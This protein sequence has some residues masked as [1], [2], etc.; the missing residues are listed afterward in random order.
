MGWKLKIWGGG[1]V[2]LF[3]SISATIPLPVNLSFLTGIISEV[4]IY[5]FSITIMVNSI[6]CSFPFLVILLI[7]NLKNKSNMHFNLRNLA[8]L[9]DINYLKL[10]INENFN[11]KIDIKNLKEGMVLNKYYFNNVY[12]YD[13]I[14]ENSGNLSCYLSKNDF[15]YS[16]YFKS[17][18]LAGIEERDIVLL[19][20]L[21]SQNFLKNNFSI[22]QSFPFAP[23]ILLGFLIAILFGDLALIIFKSLKIFIQVIL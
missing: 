21:Y 13:S 20:I 18:S 19:K 12:V 8:I 9:F 16:Y 22:K 1:D 3:T 4:A 15:K 14:N 17:I 5:P 11:Q 23:S 10:I 7:Y 6:L 2:K